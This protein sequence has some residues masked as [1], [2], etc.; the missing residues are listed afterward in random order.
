MAR[1]HRVGVKSVREL[2]RLAQLEAVFQNRLAHDRPALVLVEEYVFLSA[3]K[4]WEDFLENAFASLS[5][6][7]DPVAG[8]RTYPY[9]SPKT[10]NHA[11]EMIRLEKDFTDWTSPDVVITRAEILFRNH[12][13]IT[14]PIKSALSDLRDA[15]RIR[16]FVA[17]GSVESERLF[18]AL[19]FNRTGKQ[20]RTAGDFLLERPAGSANH[21]TLYFTSRFSALVNQI[22]N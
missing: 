12:R 8:R 22:A 13:V 6:Y 11:L 18:R 4:I 20:L 9:L 2:Q 7:N 5:R 19:A 16:N 15:K 10:E 14:D 17:H 21:F 1:I 3:F